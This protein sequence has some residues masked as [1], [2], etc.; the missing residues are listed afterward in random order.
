MTAW[1]IALLVAALLTWVQYGVPRRSPAVLLPAVLR[2]LSVLLLAALILGAPAGVAR[3]AQPMVA[4]DASASWLRASDSAAWRSAVQAARAA[5]GETP[6]LFGD[7]ARTYSQTASPSDQASRVRPAV[8]RAIAA[9]RPLVVITDGMLDDPD[10]LTGLPSGS[11]VEVPAIATLAD[12]AI[13]RIEGPSSAVSGDTSEI[14]V[15][16]ASGATPTARATLLLRSGT[17]VLDTIAVEPLGA[18]T[19]RR[20]AVRVPLRG[21]GP[22][23]LTAL[24]RMEGDREARNDT[25]S[26]VVELARGAAAVF[27][28]TSPN[29]DSR[30]ALGVLRGA[31]ALPTRAYV[32]VARGVWKLEGPLSPVTVAEVRAALRDAPLAVIHGDTAIF[33][34][35]RATTRGSLALWPT[36]IERGID[37]YAVG[38]PASPLMGALSQLPW[39]SLPPLDVAASLPNGDWVGLSVA[40]GRQL[41]GRPA[42]VGFERGRRVV[43]VGVS[44]FWRWRFRGGASEA[45][46]GA[47]WGTVFDWLAAGRFDARAAVPA[48]TSFRSGEPI[49]WQRGSGVDSAVSVTL[50]RRGSDATPVALSLFFGSAATSESGPLD[51]G[52]YDVSIRG[53]TTMIAVNASREL[54]PRQPTVSAGPIGARPSVGDAPRLRERMWPF[55]LVVLALCAEWL[56]RRR[57]GLR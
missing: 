50:R 22:T 13:S 14:A 41:D 16:L 17:A 2:F 11:R 10:A 21:V 37:W 7:S 27:V 43:V 8:D 55:I 56:L 26:A 3:K 1:L 54:L 6:L 51:P 18:F 44:G 19:E 33:G 32:Q 47:L 23:L 4:L 31:L 12:V 57:A 5:S 40:R 30:F 29:E 28:S 38:A 25:A 52:V 48:L 34:A 46:Y 53:G 9:G 45:A 36:S 42:I 24:V 39:D 35:P 15:T 20:L 49:R